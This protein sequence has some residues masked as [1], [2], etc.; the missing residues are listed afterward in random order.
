[1]IPETT[2]TTEYALSRLKDAVSLAKAENYFHSLDRAVIDLEKAI[3]A[4]KQEPVIPEIKQKPSNTIPRKPDANG[5]TWFWLL[6]EFIEVNM[7]D[8]RFGFAHDDH[9]AAC[10]SAIPIELFLSD[11]FSASCKNVFKY[12]MTRNGEEIERSI[13][14]PMEWMAIAHIR[15]CAVSAKNIGSETIYTFKGVKR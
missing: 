4:D 10:L 11:K 7:H 13:S 6:G 2:Y 12:T 8:P 15:T 5:V 3:L 9:L 1:M 14:Y